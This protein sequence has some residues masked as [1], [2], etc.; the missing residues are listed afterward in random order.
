M[1]STSCIFTTHIIRYNL[2]KLL[3]KQHREELENITKNSDRKEK[4]TKSQQKRKTNI[5]RSPKRE[6]DLVRTVKELHEFSPI[7]ER[8][9]KK[10]GKKDR[11]MTKRANI[12]RAHA[13]L[14]C[15]DR[16][17]IASRYDWPRDSEKTETY[18]RTRASEKGER[19]R[20]R[21]RNNG[22]RRDKE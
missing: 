21:R 1:L 3:R 13:R 12:D 5:T 10:T 4:V 9:K 7:W 15:F 17:R 22:N 6:R 14:S 18:E 8:V 2:D 20:E 16:N 11:S 19:E